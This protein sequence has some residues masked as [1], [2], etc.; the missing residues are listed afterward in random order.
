[1]LFLYRTIFV[2]VQGRSLGMGR[3]GRQSSEGGKMNIL[4]EKNAFLPSYVELLFQMKG[5]SINDFD[6]IVLISRFFVRGV[7]CAYLP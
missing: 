4:N 2:E 1:M 7:P 5:N 3:P 6:W